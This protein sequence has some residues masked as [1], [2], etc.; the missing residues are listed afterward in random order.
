M[1]STTP[2]LPS[3]QEQSN[4]S[5]EAQQLPSYQDVVR[6]SGSFTGDDPVATPESRNNVADQLEHRTGEVETR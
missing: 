4:A 3:G 5:N 1:S 6:L 2:S